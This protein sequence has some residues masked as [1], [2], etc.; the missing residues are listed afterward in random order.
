MKNKELQE[1]SV[2]ELTERLNKEKKIYEINRL[3]NA[4]KRNSIYLMN[5]STLKTSKN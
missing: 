4:G 5:E 2:E 1:M 3:E